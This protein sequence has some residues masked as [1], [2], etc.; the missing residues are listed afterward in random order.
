MT[1]RTRR[2]G[3]GP[4]TTAGLCAGGASF[5]ACCLVEEASCQDAKDDR[6]V[7]LSFRGARACLLS[8]AKQLRGLPPLRP[9]SPDGGCPA[10]AERP[11]ELLQR[12]PPM[13]QPPSAMGLRELD[14]RRNRCPK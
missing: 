5:S 10:R 8:Q 1:V 3:A 11:R 13:A 14:V 7:E 2:A 12:N 9:H 4:R 6:G